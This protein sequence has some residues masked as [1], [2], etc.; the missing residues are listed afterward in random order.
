MVVSVD[1][2]HG[3]GEQVYV[4]LESF[5]YVIIKLFTI[6]TGVHTDYRAVER[7]RILLDLF[8][9]KVEIGY[10]CQVIVLDGIGIETDEF[11]TG[12]YKTEIIIT[13]NTGKDLVSRSQKI[14]VA[15]K[16]N[17]R[18]TQAA[19]YATRPFKFFLYAR[20]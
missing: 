7:C 10:C 19:Q 3:M 12:G 18:F 14:M 20:V 9:H 17:I 13:P 16:G 1:T 5:C 4:K 6:W 2:E 11:D 8:F 15:D